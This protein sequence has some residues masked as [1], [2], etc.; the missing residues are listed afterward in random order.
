[1]KA[2]L[3]ADGGARGNPGPAG[4]GVVLATPEGDVIGELAEVSENQRAGEFTV[5]KDQYVRLNTGW[6]SDRSACYL[7]AGRPVTLALT[8]AYRLQVRGQGADGSGAYSFSL[9][10]APAKPIH[11]EVVS[12]AHEN[13]RVR[14]RSARQRRRQWIGHSA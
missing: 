4:I 8:G 13:E 3:H 2:K 7:A 14:A 1:M 9:Q 11:V 6:F 5:A 12:A 10:A